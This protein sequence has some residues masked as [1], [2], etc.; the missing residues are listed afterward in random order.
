[1]VTGATGFIGAAI[2]RSLSANGWRVDRWSRSSA[3]YGQPID[4]AHLESMAQRL[5]ITQ[6][7]L[8]VH[9][10]GPASVSDATRS[11]LSD[12]RGSLT[13]W[14]GV[15]ESVRLSGR[16]P[17]I[18]LISSASVY[19]QPNV[20]PI[21]ESTPLQP[22]SS[23]GYNRALV[24]LVA[25]EYS[26]IYGFSITITRVFSTYGAA[27]RRLLIWELAEQLLNG[28]NEIVLRGTGEELRDYMHIDDLAET[29]S[30]LASHR[31]NRIQTAALEIV[32]VASGIAVSTKQI[33][34]T[35]MSAAGVNG[36]IRCLGSGDVHAPSRWAV[37]VSHLRHI[38]PL[39]TRSL[40]D[41]LS[42]CWDSWC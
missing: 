9:C 29:I 19:G 1:M 35:L 40:T 36:T 42:D 14:T 8:I 16:K 33:A 11:P 10:A 17:I 34:E 6:P 28:S 15:L 38:T 2:D 13:P 20:L 31:V 22:L 5:E 30:A 23:Y 24:E 18:V 4:Y 32:N 37:D 25:R 26:A 21:L 41:G 7:D 3:R 27:Q 39:A 12:M